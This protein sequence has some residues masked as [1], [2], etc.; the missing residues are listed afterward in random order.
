MRCNCIESY[1]ARLAHGREGSEKVSMVVQDPGRCTDM[2]AGSQGEE[3]GNEKS[4]EN[5]RQAE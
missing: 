2:I 4:P 3:V 5:L 1:Y